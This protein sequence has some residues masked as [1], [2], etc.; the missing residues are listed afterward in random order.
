MAQVLARAL[1]PLNAQ[2]PSSPHMH[3]RTAGAETASN[4]TQSSKHHPQSASC[5][6]GPLAAKWRKAGRLK[7]IGF[8]RPR[9]LLRSNFSWPGN[10]GCL[11][12]ELWM[13]ND[14][15]SGSSNGGTNN[16]HRDTASQPR[17]ILDGGN[18]IHR[19]RNYEA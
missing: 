16:V 2:P 15:E 4:N 6:N 17:M 7:L 9:P 19:S 10:A 1:S 8:G 12:L 18:V 14:A 3:G 11:E 5:R 13:G